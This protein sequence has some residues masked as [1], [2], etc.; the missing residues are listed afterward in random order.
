MEKYKVEQY[1]Y[2]S[3]TSISNECG[4][5]LLLNANSY[6]AQKVAD[7]L[8]RLVDKINQANKI[9]AAVNAGYHGENYCDDVDGAN[10]FDLA[11]EFLKENK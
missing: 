6:E 11:E 2:E 5:G 3:S 7:E 9:I 4:D 10:W 8:N 1:Q